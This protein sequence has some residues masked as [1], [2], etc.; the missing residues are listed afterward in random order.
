MIAD[1]TQAYEL[2]AIPF[3][4]VTI[5][6]TPHQQ[7][8]VEIAFAEDGINFDLAIV[9]CR[10]LRLQTIHVG[11]LFGDDIHHTRQCHTAIERRGR[12]AQH[13]YLFHFLQRDTEIGGSGIRGITVQAVAVEHD[14][15]LLLRITVDAAHGDVDIIVTVD[16]VH[17]RHVGCQ[18]FL[19]VTGTAGLDHLGCDERGRYRHL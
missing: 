9:S 12:S 2:V 8:D 10:H 14:Q 4:A 19:Q 1:A 5:A 6:T 11:S 18:H 15:D 3:A 17:A 16:E 7:I 13:F